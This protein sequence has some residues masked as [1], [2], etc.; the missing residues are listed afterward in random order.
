[1]E[2]ALRTLGE[3][4]GSPYSQI[5]EAEFVD[6]Q[7]GLTFEQ[8]LGNRAAE[9]LYGQRGLERVQA[10]IAYRNTIQGI[11][12]DVKNS[13]RDLTTNYIL[14]SRTRTL[15]IAATEDLRTLQAEEDTTQGLTPEFLNLKLQRQTA[16][17]AAEQQEITALVDFN[18]SMAR[19]HTATGTSLERNKIRFYAPP[20]RTDPSTSRLFPD[21]PLEP[22]RPTMDEIRRK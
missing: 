8:P 18:T 4:V 5:G 6:Y 21:F 19:L 22:E 20:A 3:H 11:V 17:S 13:L 1:M 10:A 7:I 15:R 2:T 9:A 14:V 16:L 12:A